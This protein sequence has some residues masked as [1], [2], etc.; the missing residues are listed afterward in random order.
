MLAADQN[1]SRPWPADNVE[2]WPIDKLIP[3]ARNSRVHSDSQIKQLVGSLREWGWTMPVLVGEDGVLIAGHARVM[4]ARKLGISEVPTM[5]AVGWSDAQKRAYVI[6]DNK[7][8]LNAS[9]DPSML[10]SE[11]GDINTDGFSMDLVG[12][13]PGE[14]EALLSGVGPRVDGGDADHVPAPPVQPVTDPGDVWILGRH[15]LVCGDSTNPQHVDRAMDGA[16]ANFCFTSPP[17]GQQRDYKKSITDW[18]DLMQGV[19]GILPVKPDAQVFV[20]LGLIHRDVEWVPY[21][22]SWIQFM[23]DAGWRRFGWYVWDQGCGLQGDFRGRLAPSFEFIFHFN[24][25]IVKP[26]R[27]VAKKPENIRDKTF[28]AVTPKDAKAANRTFD[29][30]NYSPKSSMNTHK[31]PDSVI[32][33]NRHRGGLGESGAHPAVFPVDLVSEMM[34]AFSS[35]GDHVYEPFSGSGTQILAA[36]KNDR[37]CS[38][39]EIEPSYVDVS[40]RRWQKF[41]GQMAVHEETGQT[42]EE[43][44]ATRGRASK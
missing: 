23:R 33:V 12:F 19:F 9:F 25:E 44:A 30:L 8:A 40:V 41:A 4:A 35:S 21:W 15:R 22:D 36:Q 32:R 39:I 6:A 28:E 11:L 37:S 2:R 27:T 31:I 29:T 18:D 43:I 13:S 3:Y 7:L 34:C 10:A 17:Y 5:V 14:I 26:K 1:N 20:N 24:R 16:Q 38:A 42:F